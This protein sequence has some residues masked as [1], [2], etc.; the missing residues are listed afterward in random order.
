M[1]ISVVWFKRDLR[2]RDHAPLT[3]AIAAGRPVFLMYCFEPELV[4]DP[5]YSSRHWRFVGE[6][7]R[8]INASLRCFGARVHVFSANPLSVFRLLHEQFGVA[9]V[10]SHEETGLEITFQR[11][12]AVA[13]YLKAVGATWQETA[14]NG[15]QRGR[16]DRRGWNRRWRELMN[17]PQIQPNLEHLQPQPWRRDGPLVALLLRS[18][19]ASWVTEDAEFQPGGPDAADACMQS[20][21][22]DRGRDYEGNVSSPTASREHCSRLSPYLAWGNL[23]IRQVYQSLEA[24]RQRYGWDRSMAA[25]ESRLHWHCHFIQKFE[26][27]RRME[28]EDVNRGYRDML[29]PPD[30]ELQAAWREGRTGFPIVD[31]N[32]RCLQATGHT[33]FRM[34]AMLVS[35]FCHHLWQPW[36]DA[37]AH[38]ASLFL[39]FEP[40]IHYAQLQMQAGVTGTNTIRIY[41]PVKQSQEHDPNGR[42]IRRW[43][44]EL[45]D[46]P[47][48]LLH[49]P[50]E[51]TPMERVLELAEYP[52]PIVDHRLTYRRARDR[53]WA[54]RDNPHVSS[55]AAR[56]LDRHVER[57]PLTG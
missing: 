54:M 31:A 25:F 3:N 5:R 10:Y 49:D 14:T 34:R 56:I 6:S 8:D 30:A 35:F 47:L 11:D 18:P 40:G 13:T 36:Q 46:V 24:N 33:N 16:R 2:L 39:D 26:M 32:M 57:R 28:Y 53:L 42:F 37:A 50:S 23:S 44:P 17:S 20:F 48:H 9:A 51:A 7:L 41:N 45:R 29:R 38:L 15:I 22:S 19:P 1:S 21:F 43:L 27:E 12:K 4:N 52:E 55:E